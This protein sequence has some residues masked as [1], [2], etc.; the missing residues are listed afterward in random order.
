MSSILERATAWLTPARRRA[1][2]TALGAVGVVLVLLGVSTESAV[3]GWVG[4]IDAVLAVA[5]LLLASWKARRVDWTAIY[6]VLAVLAGALKVAGILNDG[7]ESHI[8]DLLA[9]GTAAAPLIIAAVRTS[10]KTPTGEPVQEYRA[11]H[12]KEA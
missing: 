8:L 12:T 1:V 6:A 11:R 7:Q 2:Y 3:T 10:P 5:A 4:V 9:A